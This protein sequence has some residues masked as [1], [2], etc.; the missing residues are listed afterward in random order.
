MAKLLGETVR[1]KFKMSA[2]QCC[3]ERED[4]IVWREYVRRYDVKTDK[5]GLA[6]VETKC[7]IERSVLEKQVK[8]E[9]HE[10]NIQF[11][12]DNVLCY[13]IQ[14][15]MSQFMAKNCQ[16]FW[17]VASLFGG[18]GRPFCFLRVF[19]DVAFN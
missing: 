12:N 15:P 10:K 14:F 16:Y 13:M 9:E 6:V 11:R 2:K 4:G 5:D 1:F 18:F 3:Q 8:D 19:L 7:L 17:I